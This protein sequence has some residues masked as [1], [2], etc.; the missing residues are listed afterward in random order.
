MLEGQESADAASPRSRWGAMSLPALWTYALALVRR[1]AGQVRPL[2]RTLAKLGVALAL[3]LAG[4]VALS[5][6]TGTPMA[7]LT[8]DLAATTG[9]KFYI[10]LL[11]GLGALLW[12]AAA[13]VSL[14]GSVVLRHVGGQQERAGCLRG[15]AL[16]LAAL[17]ADDFFML[18]EVVYPK[19]GLEE[20]LLVLFYGGGFLALLLRYRALVLA[21]EVLLLLLG[22]LLF[23]SSVLV[24]GFL[25][26]ATALEDILK[27][28]GIAC[29]LSYF[30]R[31][32]LAGLR[33]PGH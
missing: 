31:L 12:A 16:L 13:A 33:P 32:A 3:T 18:H 6:A 23:V 25:R 7:L 17:G 2:W 1:S 9:A 4:L 24:D 26:D 8:R 11:S 22:G 14:F 20:E 30:W 27:F 21:S 5:A 29:W 19:F 28:A 15:A 10:G